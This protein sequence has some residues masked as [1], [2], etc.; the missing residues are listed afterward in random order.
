MV[1]VGVT[2]MVIKP[3]KKKKYNVFAILGDFYRQAT[4]A[5]VTASAWSSRNR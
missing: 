2:T 4:N 5:Q 3:G 1:V